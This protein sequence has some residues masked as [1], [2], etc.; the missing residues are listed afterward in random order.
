MTSPMLT[1]PDLGWSNYFLGQLDIDQ[2]DAGTPARVVSV[3]RDRL[4][5]ITT[6]GPLSVAV[7]PT[8]AEG[9]PGVGDWLLVHP[10]GSALLLE[11]KS[12]LTRRAAGHSPIPQV[13]AAN[14]DTCLITTS[15][16]ADFNPA[17]L[18]RY[19]ALCLQA[20]VT[21][22]I[23]L[24]KADLCDD[25]DI[26]TDRARALMV[27]LDAVALNAHAPDQVSSALAPWTGTGQT[28]ALV[29]S[30]GVGK[31][32]IANTL[33]GA[34]DDTQAIR[35]DDAKGRHTTTVRLM[36]RLLAGGWLIDTPGMRELRMLDAAEGI[37]N[38]FDDIT[39]LTAQ[40]RFSDGAHET[41]PGCALTGAVAAGQLDPERLTR[42]KKLQQEDQQNTRTVA[43]ARAHF[44]AKQ[45]MYNT[46][47][48]R[49]RAKRDFGD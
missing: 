42:W 2:L 28:I 33:T 18:E 21:P 29:G 25:P 41:E 1:L 44:K 49:G 40:C 47:K 9:Q 24:T 31:T 8:L 27:G 15:C 26:Y 34:Q 39:E 12:V 13:I 5:T 4:D 38:L 17:R 30:S 14:L 37:E 7:T 46:G 16:N 22:V 20:E 43:E 45:K 6:N 3:H 48:K 11:R 32:T 19:L 23:V 35:D 36:R 10:D